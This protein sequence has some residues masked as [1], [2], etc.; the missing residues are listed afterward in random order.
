MPSVDDSIRLYREFLQD[1][2]SSYH[3]SPDIADTL[4]TPIRDWKTKRKIARS[5]YILSIYHKLAKD[6]KIDFMENVL[7]GLDAVINALDDTIDIKNP[8]KRRNGLVKSLK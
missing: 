4:E 1:M 2:I 8:E 7:V 6:D 5:S 3:I